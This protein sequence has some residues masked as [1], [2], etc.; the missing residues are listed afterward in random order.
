MDP[1]QNQDSPTKEE[2]DGYQEGKQPCTLPRQ[3]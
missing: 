2:G 3:G 1:K